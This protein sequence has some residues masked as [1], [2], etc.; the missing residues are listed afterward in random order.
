MRW[1]GGA[2]GALCLSFDNLGEV[3]EVELAALG[4]RGLSATFFV[5][6]VNAELYPETL[7]EVAAQG[8]EVA[9]H[10]WR[11]ER[12]GHLSVEEQA[13]NLARGRAAFEA[14]G[15]TVSGLRPPGGQLGAGGTGALG[16]AGLLYCS[17]AG[18]GV[19]VESDVAVLPFQWRHVDATCVLPALAP[20]REAMTGSSDPL[21]PDAFV[22]YLQAEL[23]R[24]ARDGGFASIVLHPPMREW[25]G[26]RNLSAL[27]DCIAATGL[28]V[29]RFDEAAAHALS[30]AE[31]L[32]GGTT[33]DST[34]W[35]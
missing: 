26:E 14:L 34:S 21:E 2:R 27:L 3:A 5:E 31:A 4:E 9:Y 17:P 35:A 12:W 16:E 29:A 7:R 6:G 10:A 32:T 19:G 18:E 28:W 24:L 15:L 25:L 1:L 20:V 33:L 23:E 8:H 11:H 22:A 30:R 13:A